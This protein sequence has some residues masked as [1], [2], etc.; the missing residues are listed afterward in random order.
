VI[1]NGVKER[2]LYFYYEGVVNTEIQTYKCKKCGNKFKTDISDVVD[3]NSNFTHEFKE[4]CIE[5]AG[6]FF[7]SIRKIAL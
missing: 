1:K 3:G 7:G 5:L 2:K 4:K 6:L